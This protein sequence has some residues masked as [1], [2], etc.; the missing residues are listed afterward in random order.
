LKYLL[1]TCVLSE[2]GRPTP[3][4]AVEACLEGLN[5]FQMFISV[6]S[7]GEISKGI[8]L[9]EPGKKRLGFERWFDE[10]ELEYKGRV[11]PVTE[12]IARIWGEL[13][14]NAKRQGIG[15]P[16]VDGLIA[17]TAIEHGMHLLTRNVQDFKGTGVLI[18]NPWEAG[19]G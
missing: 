17:A 15:L 2:L 11:L 9:L 13:L 7:I 5:D 4:P 10:L 18:I 19:I 1:D 8:H 12:N 3:N 6:I 16:V 14:A